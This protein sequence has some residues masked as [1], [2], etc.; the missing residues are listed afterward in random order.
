MGKKRASASQSHGCLLP[1]QMMEIHGDELHRQRQAAAVRGAVVALAFLLPPPQNDAPRDGLQGHGD[2]AE[3]GDGGD[4]ARLPPLLHVEDG[5]ALEDVDDAQH[6]DGVA[7]RVVVGVPV[8]PVLVVLLRPQEE[9]EDLANGGR[10]RRRRRS[11]GGGRRSFHAP[12][13]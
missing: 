5:H 3:D 10:R 1:L 4:V 11:A 13:G 2:G 12:A 8:H 9:R 6:D 7:D